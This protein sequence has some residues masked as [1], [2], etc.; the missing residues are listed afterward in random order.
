MSAKIAY[1]QTFLLLWSLLEERIKLRLR[2]LDPFGS[3][4]A[5]PV[6]TAQ[7]TI[8]RPAPISTDRVEGGGPRALRYFPLAEP[9]SNGGPAPPS[10]IWVKFASL[11][12]RTWASAARSEPACPQNQKA[13]G[14]W[15]SFPGTGRAGE[16]HDRVAIANT[17]Y[18]SSP[19]G[20]PARGSAYRKAACASPG[21]RGGHR[22]SAFKAAD[23]RTLSRHGRQAPEPSKRSSP[24]F[25]GYSRLGRI[26]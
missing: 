20:R 6:R 2:C 16:P 1:N 12:Y 10:P 11:I 8:L 4:G 25:A 26:L 13:G 17:P 3:C 24:K 5:C 21:P 19:S 23:S 7:R 22:R 18:P 9:S 14:R 15:C